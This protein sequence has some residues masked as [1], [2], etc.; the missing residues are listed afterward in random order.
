MRY[1]Y[2]NIDES[3]MHRSKGQLHLKEALAKETPTWDTSN[4]TYGVS[5]NYGDIAKINKQ[6]GF[7]WKHKKSKLRG[8]GK[9]VT[10]AGA[11]EDR[12]LDSSKLTTL[13]DF[14]YGKTYLVKPRT[15]GEKLHPYVGP[16]YFKK[17]KELGFSAA[18]KKIR[19][20][21]MFSRAMSGAKPLIEQSI[22]NELTRYLE[23]LANPLADTKPIAFSKLGAGFEKYLKIG[24]LAEYKLNATKHQ[25][26][27]KRLELVKGKE[28]YTK[29]ANVYRTKIA[30]MRKSLKK[31]GKKTS[32]RLEQA[33]K[34]QKMYLGNIARSK[35]GLRMLR[36]PKGRKRR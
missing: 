11:Y 12:E 18:T 29:L 35:T 23:G 13:Q 28:N 4:A 36:T 22:F 15:S 24:N 30:K 14:E 16:I 34:R 20:Q 10:G 5:A 1:G 26:R 32:G 31:Q 8:Y 7:S 27:I 21:R 25:A 17:G 9:K 6:T 2:A 33:I 3:R 19:P